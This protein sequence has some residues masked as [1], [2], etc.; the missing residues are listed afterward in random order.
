M[1]KTLYL[2]IFLLGSI[3]TISA[4]EM[5][6][7]SGIKKL[8]K[9]YMACKTNN[10]KAGI[11]NQGENKKWK[12]NGQATTPTEEPDKASTAV[13]IKNTASNTTNKIKTSATDAGEKFKVGA[14][15]TANNIKKHFNNAF[16][17]STKQYP[18]GIKK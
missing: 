18:K 11:L 8:S 14:A 3:T 17:K 6:D 10:I 4:A 1:K 12:N 5:R 7:C 16:K 2:I 9:D 15:N 13:K